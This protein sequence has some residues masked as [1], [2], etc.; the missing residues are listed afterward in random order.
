MCYIVITEIYHHKSMGRIGYGI[1]A[2]EEEDG[3]LVIL[4]SYS[5]ISPDYNRVKAF[6]D[7]CN[8]GELSRRHF[9]DAVEDFLG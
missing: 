1:A 8:I 9:R 2:A 6:A 5:D 3:V 7:M 4:E